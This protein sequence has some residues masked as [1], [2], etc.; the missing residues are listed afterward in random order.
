MVDEGGCAVSGG[1][2]ILYKA[3][4]FLSV[5]LLSVGRVLSSS[6]DEKRV[7][8]VTGN[9]S[10]NDSCAVI[11]VQSTGMRSGA[12]CVYVTPAQDGHFAQTVKLFP[13]QNLVTARSSSGSTEKYVPLSVERPTLRVELNYPG[14]SENDCYW[15]EFSY[16]GEVYGIPPGTDIWAWGDYSAHQG[17]VF[18]HAA[19]G[20][21]SVSVFHSVERTIPP[22]ATTTVRVYLNDDLVY[23]ASNG[24]GIDTWSVGTFILH[25]G[26]SVGGYAVD[27][28]K[29]LDVAGQCELAG[30]DRIGYGA[31]SVT[32]LEGPGGSAP[33]FLEV[34]D[35]AQFTA[36]GVLL[37]TVCGGEQY[38][39]IIE[40]FSSS[41]TSVGD[42][43]ALGVFVAKSTGHTQVSI[44]G[45]GGDPIDVYVVNVDINGDY[46]RDGVP[47]DNLAEESAVSFE[48]PKGMVI[49][50]NTDDDVDDQNKQ[51]DCD[52][53]V[54]NGA[55]DLADIYT[56]NRAKLGI[57]AANIPSGLALELSVENPSG[58]PVGTPAAKD[59]IR[60]FRSMAQDS[61]GV[62]GPGTLPD[63]VIFKKNPGSS[64]M[65]IDLLGG[66]GDLE[67]GLEGIAFGREVIV[68]LALKLDAKKS[69]LIRFD[70]WC[71][72]SSPC[73]MLKQLPD[74]TWVLLGRTFTAKLKRHSKVLFPSNY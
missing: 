71:R 6:F 38:T 50:A 67:M 60:I 57:A 39:Q 27:D 40:G 34:G 45:Y 41:D 52:D 14:P 25:S 73:R 17:F 51:P 32:H 72:R 70:Y 16:N 18:E 54:I 3:G 1:R 28:K 48:G 43:D 69:A 26:E 47:E 9:V 7:L 46:N 24:N 68:K 66:T 42:I 61:Q 62:I 36:E 44:Q 33:V 19:A 58:E 29:R 15:L 65:D 23:T 64:D 74:V 56:L 20:R 10:E 2:R 11:E 63:T 49:L 4:V 35:A 8:P 59:R 13:G 31:L 12:K 53:S 30:F 37:G 5:V 55:N 21:Y 22:P